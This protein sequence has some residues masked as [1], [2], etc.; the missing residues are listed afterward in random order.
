MNYPVVIHKD[1]DSDYGVIV[2]DL[3]GCFSAGST[4]EDAID[5]AQEAILCH[6]E[7]LLDDNE[8]IP[9]PSSIEKYRNEKDYKGGTW[10]VV[11]IDLAMLSQKSKRVNIT[12]P[13]RFLSQVDSYAH[14]NGET[15]SGFLLHA[16]LEY[17][18][19][20]E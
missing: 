6:I 3:P 20:H 8:P 14:K 19:N 13:E 16:A 15:R 1:P 17:I 11:N 2:P 9:Q 10:A 5:K 18:A 4:M 7:G 12:I